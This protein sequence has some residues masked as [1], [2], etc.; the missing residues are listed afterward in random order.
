MTILKIK[1]EI[2]EALELLANTTAREGEDANRTGLAELALQ[3]ALSTIA[4]MASSLTA[5]SSEQIVDDDLGLPIARCCVASSDDALKVLKQPCDTGNGCLKFMWLR[6]RD[7]T[8]ML[9]VFPQG[10]T[11]MDVSDR[12]VCDFWGGPKDLGG[13]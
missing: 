9:G 1:K 12:G 4:D 8:L 2:T 11:Y 6:L 10:D 5:N 3:R 7:G 13:N